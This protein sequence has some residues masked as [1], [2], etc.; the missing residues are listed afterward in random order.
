M[1]PPHPPL[2]PAA[3]DTAQ[4]DDA[5][6]PL[7]GTERTINGRSRVYFDGY[8]IKA[9]PVPDDTLVEK[10]RLIFALTR[11]LFNH[12]EHGLYVPGARLEET[13]AA[14]DGETDPER[15][16]VKG[17]M[18]A[19]ALFNRAADM[20][21]KLVELQAMGIEIGPS[22]PLM[23]RCG[24]H[25]QEALSLGRLVKHRSGEE[26]IDELWGEPFKAF[27]FPIREF[28]HSRYVKLSMMM[29]CIDDMVLK[30]TPTLERCPGHAGVTS[31]ILALAEAAKEYAQSLRTDA[32]VF[33]TWSALAVAK[34]HLDAHRAQLPKR[35]P[36]SERT[37]ALEGEQLI[38]ELAQLLFYL[39]RA[40]V[41][42]PKSAAEICDRCR[43]LSDS[44]DVPAQ[45]MS[46]GSPVLAQR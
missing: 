32:D 38:K 19:A 14:Y 40:R 27:A 15:K 39:A 12:V 43:L 2:S 16:R 26:G 9:Y 18:V 41:P 42:M 10:Q 46:T 7:E 24:Q 4:V 17:G 3:V 31:L 1:Q 13:R 45:A 21:T 37:L 44:I 36:N 35:A 29:R 28:F 23:R 20:L 30:A 22:D 33:D 34:E 8:W 11:R 5:T 6:L 25:L